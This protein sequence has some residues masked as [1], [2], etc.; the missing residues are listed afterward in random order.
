MKTDVRKWGNSLAV[1][2]PKN[3]VEAAD[4][5]EGDVLELS[6]SAPGRLELTSEKKKLTLLDLVEAITPQN[7]HEETDWGGPLGNEAW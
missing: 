5:Q 1:R 4:L 7:Q 3:A 6:V 2:L